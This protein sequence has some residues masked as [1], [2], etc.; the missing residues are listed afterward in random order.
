[1]SRVLIYISGG[2]LLTQENLSIWVR[3][4]KGNMMKRN[5]F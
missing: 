1:M 2:Y 3:F 4:T 5:P